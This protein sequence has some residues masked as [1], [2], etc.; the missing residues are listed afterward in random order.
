MKLLNE[1]IIKFCP[2]CDIDFQLGANIESLVKKYHNKT[3][4][5]IIML[6]ID[7]I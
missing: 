4:L 2:V 7:L 3:D 1:I 6:Q 5:I